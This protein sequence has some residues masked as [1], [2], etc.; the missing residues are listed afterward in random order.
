MKAYLKKN[1]QKMNDKAK[2]RRR[3]DLAYRLR[4]V[5]RS[6]I[7]RYIKKK[8]TY[9]YYT[10]YTVEELIKNLESKFKPGMNWANHSLRGWHI[11]HIKPLSKFKFYNPDGSENIKEIRKA[12]ALSNLTCL[13]ASDN[14]SKGNKYNEEGHI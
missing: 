9:S 1:S 6:T 11:D 2:A 10:N 3:V 12:M 14:I 13:W 4:T 5:L 7:N 8:D